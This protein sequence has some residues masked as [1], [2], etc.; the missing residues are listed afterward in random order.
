M[1]KEDLLS[2]VAY[3][4]MIIIALIVGFVV[5]KPLVSSASLSNPYLITILSIILGIIFNSLFLEVGHVIGAKI[6]GYSIT[7]F[8]FL[9]ICFYRDGGKWKFGLKN[10]DGLSGETRI[11]PKNEKAN[12]RPYSFFP[13]FLFLIEILGALGL[14]IAAELYS[15]AAGGEVFNILGFGAI[16]FLA[17]GAM[18]AVYNLFPARLDTMNDGYRLV[19]FMKPVN[20]AAFNEL[21]R[22]ENLQREG[23]EVE[24]I[25]FFDEITDYTA[26]LNLTLVYNCLEKKEYENAEALIDKIIVKPEAI[27]IQTYNR[28]IAQKLYIELMTKNIDDVKKYYETLKD[29][30]KRFI[31]ND[32]SMESVRAYVLI[33]GLIEES[34][35]EVQFANGRKKRALKNALASRAEVEQNLYKE[36]LDKV[37]EA[38]PDWDLSKG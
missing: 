25:K 9:F 11:T 8:N 12:P 19:L 15:G 24:G 38:H 17:I 7:F 31:S 32:L 5:I 26:S 4:L 2:L 33:A 1:K 36:A 29:S 20:I 35:G 28:L 18:I 14:Y 37:L 6:G 30:T 13:I 16:I 34:K 23:K 21:M 10:F 3:L 22:I 27:S